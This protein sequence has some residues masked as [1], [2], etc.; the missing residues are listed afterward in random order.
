MSKHPPKRWGPNGP[1]T[2][3]GGVWAPGGLRR[4]VVLTI[5]EHKIYKKKSTILGILK[6]FL[7]SFLTFLNAIFFQ[8]KNWDQRPTFFWDFLI[9][10]Y[11]E[12]ICHSKTESVFRLGNSDSKF[13]VHNFRPKKLGPFSNKPV[14]T[15]LSKT[16][17]IFVTKK[18][19]KSDGFLSSKTV[20][21]LFFSGDGFWTQKTVTEK[22][23][24]LR[25]VFSKKPSPFCFFFGDGFWILKPVRIYF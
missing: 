9:K 14:P 4:V 5:Y 21:V 13:R 8:D 23:Q 12:K 7:T 2:T 16:K 15:L 1:Q 18:K 20:T 10:F 19:T 3:F 25:G 11:L 6:Y 22:K 17:P 24:N